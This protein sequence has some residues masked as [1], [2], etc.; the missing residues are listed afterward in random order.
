MQ[1]YT[2]YCDFP[3]NTKG[4]EINSGSVGMSMQDSV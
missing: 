1:G 2:P 4:L 3:T